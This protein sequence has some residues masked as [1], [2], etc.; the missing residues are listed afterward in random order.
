MTDFTFPLA[1]AS[2]TED[3]AITT[4][5]FVNEPTRLSN[6]VAA[7]TQANLV[8]QHL[9]DSVTATGG[10]LMYDRIEVNRAEAS[11]KPGVIAPGAEFP[12]ISTAQGTPMIDPVVK[13]GGYYD[14]TREAEKRNDVALIRRGA[15]Q[16][17]NTMVKDIDGRG[18]AVLSDVLNSTDGALKL[19]SSGWAAAGKVQASAKTAL[20]GE[21]KLIDDLEEA[22]LL[23][24]ETDL[25]YVPD[26]LVLKRRDAKHL[27]T[28]LGVNKWKDIL[29]TL[30]FTLMVTGS[31]QL[32]NG[33]GFVLQA[34]AVGSMGV[35]DPIS[36]DSEYI[37]S[38]QTTRF[39]TW[40]SMAFGVTDPFAAV[41]LTG[42]AQ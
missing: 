33:E 20:T 16:V 36:T 31:D 41:K 18:F 34:R 9:F 35:E 2:V 13:T 38:R 22:R 39:Y 15:V 12:A 3:G 19:E 24:E 28:I 42:L 26:T 10:A 40:A 21:G 11:Q 4:S 25:G 8:T 14:L 29:D 32:Q 27:R 5:M 7:L 17:A 1:P 6:Y 37:K 23:I 30:G